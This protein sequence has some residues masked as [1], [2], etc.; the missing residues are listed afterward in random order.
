MVVGNHR[1]FEE[2]GL[3][4]DVAHA[5]VERMSASGCTAVMVARNG[6]TV[7]MIGVADEPRES[8]AAVV[9]M[10]ARARAS[11]TSSC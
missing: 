11:S 1:L 9:D 2:R 7:G 6:E 4:S 5:A 8:A 10:I 3:C